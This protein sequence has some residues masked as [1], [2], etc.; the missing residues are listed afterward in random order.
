MVLGNYLHNSNV[1]VTLSD[2]RHYPLT[3]FIWG[4]SG[5]LPGIERRQVA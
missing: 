1:A 5:F 3:S 4:N 2:V